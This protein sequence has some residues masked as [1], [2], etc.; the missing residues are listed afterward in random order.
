MW[1]WALCSLS[2]RRTWRRAFPTTRCRSSRSTWPAP[3]TTSPGFYAWDKNNFAPRFAVAWSPHADGGLFGWLTGGDKLVIR[4]GYSMVYDRIG[5]ALATRF[6]QAGSFG[7]S[8]QLSSNV[9]A[10]NEDNPDIRFQA[11]NVIPN[12]LPEAP[13]RRLPADAASR[14]RP[15]H[16]RRSTARSGRP[17]RTPTTWSSDGSLAGDY[18]FEA[19]YVGRTG[20]NQM[21]RRDLMMPLNFKDQKSG[22]DYFTAAK[23]LHRR[24][25]RLR[26]SAQHR[27]DSV[28]GERVPGGGWRSAGFRR[29]LHRHAEHG[30][31]GSWRTSRTG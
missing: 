3:P 13:H 29:E 21:I 24:G 2:A 26:R 7:L 27:A 28:L 9:N 16:E 19:A 15:D 14:G 31:S 30:A 5:Q 11:I 4:G 23:Q 20:R 17:T 12:T 22:T 8:T 1:T 6:D 10:N 18:S 25:A